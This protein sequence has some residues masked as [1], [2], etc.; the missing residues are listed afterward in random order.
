LCSKQAKEDLLAKRVI[1]EV[2]V[3]M[4]VMVKIVDVAV[5]HPVLDL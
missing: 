5:L 2:M 1:M 4:V 3:A